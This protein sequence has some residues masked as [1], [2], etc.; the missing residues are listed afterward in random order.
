M[1]GSRYALAPP[2][3]AVTAVLLVGCGGDDDSSITTV[4]TE[5]PQTLTK[6]DLIEQ[7]D[8]ICEETDTALVSL[9]ESETPG[10]ASTQIA[11]ERDL[12]E[13]MLEQLRNLGAPAEDQQTLNEFLDS[14]ESVVDNLDK[15]ELAAE[16]DDSAT[17]GELQTEEASLRAD[18]QAAATDY[19]FK[20]CGEGAGAAPTATEPGAG[21]AP[22]P[23]APA[24]PAPAAPAPPGTAAPAPPTGGTG[25]GTGAGGTGGGGGAGSGG[26]SP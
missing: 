11:Q 9:S 6:D 18:A 10:D 2:L 8:A 19:G 5:P 12:T 7:G 17:L 14:L 26:V 1:V 24:A 13:G 22:A 16:R 4:Q 25:G 20:E 23:P 15:Q 21:T 3:A